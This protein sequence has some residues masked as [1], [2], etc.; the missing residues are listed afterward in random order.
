MPFSGSMY[1]THTIPCYPSINTTESTTTTMNHN[2]HLSPEQI[3]SKMTGIL[4]TQIASTPNPSSTSTT[5]TVPNL[6]ELGTPLSDITPQPLQWLWHNRI[7]RGKLIILDG[8]PGLGK[9]LITL[10]LAARISTNQPMPDGASGIPGTPS[11]IVLI[12]LE[13]DPAD[14]LIP[15]LTAAGADL[16]A[17][18]LLNIINSRDPKSGQ[19]QPSLFSLPKHLSTLTH[20]LLHTN[21]AL[22]IIDPLMAVLAP[23]IN[24]ASDQSIR[25]VFTPLAY[26]AERTNTAILIVRHLNKTNS[27]NH[28]YRGSGSI[29]IVASART[30]LLAT[31]DPY[32]PHKFI[33]ATTK[34]NYTSKPD[35]LSY[36]I[37][38]NPHGIPTI[39]WL[40]PNYTPIT[41]LLKFPPSVS[42]ER[43]T[44]L[45][46]LEAS[47][48]P[49]TPKELT[50]QSGLN[51]QQVRQMLRRMANDGDILSPSYGLY[52]AHG[53]LPTVTAITHA[54]HTTHATVSHSDSNFAEAST[55]PVTPI[56]PVTAT[57]HA[58][59]ATVSHS[60][61]N[62][63]SLLS[64]PSQPSLDSFLEQLRPLF[65]CSFTT[66]YLHWVLTSQKIGCPIC[67]IW[68]NPTTV[69]LKP[70]LFSLYNILMQ[71]PPDQS[72]S[73]AAWLTRIIPLAPP[74]TTPPHN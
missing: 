5:P 37:V 11:N 15:R 67:D 48:I 28:L 50:A 41:S 29:G 56:S 36:Q 53:H 22:V 43:Q 59:H 19:S 16:S 32:D 52:I 31:H 6:T 24:A 4:K 69:T 21:T 17:I 27:T 18:R 47:D 66:H 40:G 13:D 34:T 58:T 45:D 62:F 23:N 49:L 44:L 14:T 12:A 9:S 57:T 70:S 2:E 10:D 8:E 39:Q 55:S 65:L 72:E 42:R 73:R 68:L 71:H 3:L 35:N 25:R 63:D 54:T 7:P 74:I 30:S 20:L 64:Q 46:I 26:L 60:D 38:S 51:H 33:L 61:S 1:H